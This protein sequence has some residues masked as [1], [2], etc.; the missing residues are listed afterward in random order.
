[1]QIAV[2]ILSSE[3]VIDGGKI[4]ISLLHRNTRSKPTHG[5]D[6]MVAALFRRRCI[7]FGPARKCNPQIARLG[8]HGELETG[9]HDANDFITASVDADTAANRARIAAEMRSPEAVTQDDDVMAGII[10][11]KKKGAPKSRFYAKNMKGVV[12]NN[13]ALDV[14][15]GACA[16]DNE[17]VECVGSY[18]FEG[19]I[20]VR[21][22]KVIRIRKLALRNF[23]RGMIAV[24]FVDGDESL[25]F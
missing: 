20:A 24:V 3:R 17:I 14:Q 23:G 12:G 21:N 4:R 18:G 11:A 25:G 9:G 16:S 5:E 1:M 7:P 19:T 10:L 6:G 22:I 15:N 2:G 13:F 8:A